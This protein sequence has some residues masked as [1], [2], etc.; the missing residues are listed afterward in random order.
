MIGV[1]IGIDG[2]L[3]TTRATNSE[4]SLLVAGS[5]GHT[6]AQKRTRARIGNVQHAGLGIRK[7]EQR[8]RLPSPGD[9]SGDA[10]V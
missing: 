3:R 1:G 7:R 8:S 4:L 6:T 10:T 9:G 5:A 2:V